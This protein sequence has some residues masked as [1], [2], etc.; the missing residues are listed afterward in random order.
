MEVFYS[1]RAGRTHLQMRSPM[2]EFV[3]SLEEIRQEPTLLQ[4]MQEDVFGHELDR[5]DA[6]LVGKWLESITCLIVGSAYGL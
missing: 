1:N 2:L 6:V 5:S 3:E 4:T